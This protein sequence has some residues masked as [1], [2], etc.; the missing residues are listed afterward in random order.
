MGERNKGRRLLSGNLPTQN[1]PSRFKPT[2]V[3]NKV[4]VIKSLFS[5]G[6]KTGYLAFNVGSFLKTPKAKETIAERILEVSEVK[7]LIK[8]GVKNERDRLLLS[9]MYGCGL[10]VSEAIGLTWDDFKK[11]GDGGKATVFGKGSKTRIVLIPDKLWQQVKEFEKY[12][13]VNQYVFISRNHNQ[14]ER[15][16]VHRMIKRACKRAGIDERASAHWLRHS[17]ASHSLEAGCNLRLLQQSLGHASVTT[18]ERYLHISPDAGSS[19]FIDF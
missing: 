15:S 4:L 9:L 6:V 14:M 18:T 1:A 17:H 2:T 11:H 16:V 8:Y 10:R 5:F 3:A 12:H 7:G 19:Q 13:R